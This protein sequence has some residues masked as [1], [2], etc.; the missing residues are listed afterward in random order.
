MTRALFHDGDT[1]HLSVER[2]AVHGD[3]LRLDTL[4]AARTQLD[5][6]TGDPLDAAVIAHSLGDLDLARDPTRLDARARRDQAAWALVDGAMT[7]HRTR[8][9]LGG[10]ALPNPLPGPNPGPAPGPQPKPEVTHWVEVRVVDQAG[11]PVVGQQYRIVLPDGA[12][13]TGST[14]AAGA[15]RFDDIDPGQ[16]TVTFPDADAQ[17][18]SRA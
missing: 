11:L 6:L 12:V 16:C 9:S 15:V 4:D 10:G 7:L 13:R 8:Q 5:T 14:N 17:D 3:P 1:W 2:T 18:I